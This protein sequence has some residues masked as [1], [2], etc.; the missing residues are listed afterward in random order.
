MTT[1]MSMN[2]RDDPASESLHD[3]DGLRVPDT[4]PVATTGRGGSSSSPA[5]IAATN[6]DPGERDSL[7]DGP[8]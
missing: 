4:C 1:P 5:R 2:G 3:L 7:V 8:R 6:L